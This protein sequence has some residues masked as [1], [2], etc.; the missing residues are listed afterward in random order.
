MK[1]GAEVWQEGVKRK[2]R[3]QTTRRTNDEEENVSS[4]CLT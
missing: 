2:K 4:L 1:K 3:G